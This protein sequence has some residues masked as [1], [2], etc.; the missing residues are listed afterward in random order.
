M[1]TQHAPLTKQ[2]KQKL[3]DMQKVHDLFV[4]TLVKKPVK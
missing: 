1:K 3:D 2:E 4:K